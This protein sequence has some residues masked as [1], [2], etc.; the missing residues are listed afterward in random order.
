MICLLCAVFCMHLGLLLDSVSTQRSILVLVQNQSCEACTVV[1]LCIPHSEKLSEVKCSLAWAPPWLP[2]ASS[3]AH[4]SGVSSAVS[5]CC[6][7]IFIVP[8][9]QPV[10]LALAEHQSQSAMTKIRPGCR[11]ILL[12]L[13]HFI[14]ATELSQNQG[15]E[16]CPGRPRTGCG[17]RCA[18]VISFL[19]LL[20]RYAR[21]EASWK[22][23]AL[24]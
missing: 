3:V 19:Q 24:A 23:L 18:S 7:W 21:E 22:S 6:M 14:K 20:T 12:P 1:A 13:T 16:R 11:D 2:A 9:G 17:C 15:L 4:C 5:L 10:S 8:L